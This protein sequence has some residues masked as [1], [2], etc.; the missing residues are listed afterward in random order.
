VLGLGAGLVHVSANKEV[1]TYVIE[2]DALGQPARITLTNDH[3]E[4]AAAQAG[5][6]VGQLVTLVRSRPLDPVVVR[7]NWK[8]AY[9]FLAGEA[10]STM[11]AYVAA[12]P[13]IRAVDG[14]PLARTV[15]EYGDQL[16]TPFRRYQYGP[17]WRRE[18][19]AGKDRFREIEVMPPR[20]EAEVFRNPLGI[21]I[22]TFSWS[23]EFT[24]P[25]LTD[26]GPNATSP[27][28][29]DLETDHESND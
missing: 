3:Y 17:V 19:K 10:I 23:K 28:A 9:G 6:F 13:P 2:V 11:N 16:T 27:P 8:K 21:Y 29:Q 12:D 15:A 7:E 5:Y 24:D 22:A 26:V 1:K 4:P 18:R 25:V 20:D 14:R